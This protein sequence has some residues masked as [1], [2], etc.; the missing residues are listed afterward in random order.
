MVNRT[1]SEHDLTFWGGSRII[2]PFGRE[3]AVAGSGEELI[4]ATLDYDDVRRARTLLPTIR[5]SNISL[6]LNETSRLADRLS[7][8]DIPGSKG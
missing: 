2:D 8:P 5:D 1:G 7:L 3:L 6:V 4:S